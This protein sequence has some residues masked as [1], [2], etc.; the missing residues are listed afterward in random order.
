MQIFFW[1]AEFNLMQLHAL[2][3][4]IYADFKDT[5]FV[6]FGIIKWTFEVKREKGSKQIY[7]YQIF[8]CNLNLHLLVLCVFAICKFEK[9]IFEY[10]KAI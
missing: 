7:F 4:E 8:I 3:M 5:L 1:G 9:N 10:V 6:Y 2:T